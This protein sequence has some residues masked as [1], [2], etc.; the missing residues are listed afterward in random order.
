[1]V[2]GT[3]E[4]HSLATLDAVERPGSCGDRWTR[5]HRYGTTVVYHQTSPAS[6]KSILA[7]GFDMGHAGTG[8]AGR[9]MYFATSLWATFKKAQHRGF[10][11]EARV[12]LGK[13]KE[14]PRHPESGLTLRS[15]NSECYDSVHIDRGYKGGD[16]YVIYAND[17]MP[18]AL[19]RQVDC[20]E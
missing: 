1:M 14:E 13:P 12:Y 11:I 16:E 15:L 5:L 17:Q 6:G 4:W 7:S 9:G 19:Y 18:K 8:I 20:H 2:H 3:Q 10:C